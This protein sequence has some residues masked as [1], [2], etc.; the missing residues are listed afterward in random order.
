MRFLF[1]KLR[2]IG[3][4][5]LL[6]PTI[7][8]TK[9]KFPDAEI[10]VLVRKSCDGILAGCAEIDRLLCTANPDASKRRGSEFF[11]DL[12]LL[13]LLRRT[14]FDH[15]FEL[16]DSDR[17]RWFAIAARA[18][19]RSTNQHRSLRWFW[20][21]FFDT[22]CTTNRYPRHQV[23]RDYICPQEVLALPSEPGGMR[24]AK[25]RMQ[26]WPEAENLAPGSYAVIHLH[27]RWERK[28]WPIDRWKLLIPHLLEMVPRIIL[29][30][31]PAPEEMASAKA[32]SETFEGRV[33][34]TQGKANW[35]QLAWILSRSAFFVGV[36]TAAMHLAAAV[37]CPTVALFGPSPAYEYHPWKVRHWMIKPQ[38]WLSPEQVKQI[39]RDDLMK[40]IPV[41]RVL[42]A[43][44]EAFDAASRCD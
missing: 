26:P 38:D 37:G 5:L 33:I 35:R 24:F 27:T 32:L 29:S 43:C 28:A 36:D 11:D 31:G 18:R 13:A 3:D 14:R 23:I 39:H 44:R 25:E 40:E 21:P 8:G 42:T 4:S 34:P 22:I 12:K 17:A 20:R 1:I 2:H 7:L 19:H 16:T 30:C 10:W 6:T 15:V 41:D 9:E